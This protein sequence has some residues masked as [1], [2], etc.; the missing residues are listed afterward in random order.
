[1]DMQPYGSWAPMIQDKQCECERSRRSNIL[2]MIAASHA[3]GPLLALLQRAD[4]QTFTFD[5]WFLLDTA[6]VVTL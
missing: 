5:L 6:G 1:M 2:K 3:P 4:L